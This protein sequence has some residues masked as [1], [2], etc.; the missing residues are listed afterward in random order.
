MDR[1]SRMG[2]PGNTALGFTMG[3]AGRGGRSHY[4]GFTLQL[5]TASAH[6]AVAAV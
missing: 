3:L 6:R 4:V 2:A 1:S 5:A